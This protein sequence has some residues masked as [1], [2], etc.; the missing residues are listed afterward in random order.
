MSLGVMPGEI[1]V[2]SLATVETLGRGSCSVPM[3]C[4]CE[5][6][7]KERTNSVIVVV[8]ASGFMFRDDNINS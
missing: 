3:P 4:A 5:V 1:A 6:M 8:R 7:I 2:L